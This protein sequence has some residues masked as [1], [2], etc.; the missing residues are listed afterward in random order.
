M[1]TLGLLGFSRVCKHCKIKI[2]ESKCKTEFAPHPPSAAL[3]LYKPSQGISLLQI[4]TCHMTTEL[5]FLLTFFPS[6]VGSNKEEKKCKHFMETTEHNRKVNY[7][8]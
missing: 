1:S 3:E 4:L 7:Q 6:W 8:S 2:L 5:S